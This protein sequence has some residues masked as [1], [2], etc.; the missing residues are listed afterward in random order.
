MEYPRYQIYNKKSDKLS[1]LLKLIYKAVFA[2]HQ[3]R[4]LV[5]F[6]IFYG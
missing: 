2:K 6:L 3:W 4:L 1:L 5:F